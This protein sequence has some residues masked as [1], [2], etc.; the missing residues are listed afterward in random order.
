MNDFDPRKPNIA[1]IYDALRDGKDNF[2]PDREAA[3]AIREMAA[4]GAAGRA[5]QPGVPLPRGTVPGG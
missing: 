4:D 5:R 3:D 1:R 2:A